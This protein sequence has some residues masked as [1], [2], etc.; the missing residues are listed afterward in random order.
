[1]LM[2]YKLQTIYLYNCKWCMA[3][4]HG[5]EKG[6]R[7]IAFVRY[8]NL[9]SFTNSVFDYKSVYKRT[10]GEI[11]SQKINYV[12]WL[13]RIAKHLTEHR[14]IT[15]YNDSGSTSRTPLSPGRSCHSSKR[16]RIQLC[17][18]KS[19]TRPLLIVFPL[20]LFLLSD[21]LMCNHTGL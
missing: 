16:Y 11:T 4:T 9:N 20:F 12:F 1:M 19:S 3:L 21:S 14:I 15:T 7:L 6:R 17:S 13:I 18:G 5:N 8:L 2:F 10:W